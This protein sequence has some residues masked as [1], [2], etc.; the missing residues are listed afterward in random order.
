MGLLYAVMTTLLNPLPAKFI[1]LTPWIS[2]QS[3]THLPQRIHLLGSLV[4]D[5]EE[6]SISYSFFSPVKCL[7]L[8][9]IERESPCSSQLL[10]LSQV[11]QSIGWLSKISSSKSLLAFLKSAVFVFI[12]IPAATFAVQLV[13]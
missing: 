11:L 1:A 6:R 12:F 13:T 4:I 10:S 3:L 8:M 9:P 5:G 7:F 2:A